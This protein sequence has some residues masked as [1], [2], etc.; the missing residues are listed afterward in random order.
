MKFSI[1]QLITNSKPKKLSNNFEPHLTAILAIS[2]DGKISSQVNQPAR[3]SS[4]QDLQHLESQIALCD[5][6]VFGGN[7][8][9]AYKTSLA[10]KT[11]ELL[12]Q[13]KNAS[14]PPQ[15]LHI[16]CSP[17]ANLQSDW[18]F[19]SQPIPRALL[20]TKQGKEHWL[21]TLKQSSQL[22][23]ESDYF[24]H[25]FINQDSIDW[26]IFL[27]QLKELNYQKIAILGGA[28]L[29]SSLL[30]EKLIDDIWLTICPVIFGQ[31]QAVSWLD[32]LADS[33]LPL[34]LK[35]ELLEVRTIASEIFVHYQIIY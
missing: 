16:V 23:Q 15:P 2:L 4:P 25:Y 18:R 7:T 34:P 1:D 10:V 29:I 17:S 22:E 3:F 11:P 35:L 28:K 12:A 33:N 14:K 8:L 24:S 32:N 13:R 27:Q 21:T 26:S 31:A 6:I 9:R 19:F 5:A 20:T 30:Q